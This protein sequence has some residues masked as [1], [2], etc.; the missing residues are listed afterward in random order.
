MNK[1]IINLKSPGILTII[2]AC[3]RKWLV[4]VRL[5][6]GRTV[7]ELLEQARKWKRKKKIGLRLRWMND[8]QQD[9]RNMGVTKF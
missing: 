1:F 3:R 6:G 4:H 2:K 7:N 5:D 9:L 8:V